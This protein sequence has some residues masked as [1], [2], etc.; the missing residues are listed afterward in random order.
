MRGLGCWPRLV[1]AG[2]LMAGLTVAPGCRSQ[3]Y[4]VEAPTAGISPHESPLVAA[5]F[6]DALTPAP[7]PGQ[8]PHGHIHVF[9]VNGVDPLNWGNM[10]GL[11]DHIRELHVAN[12]HEGQLYDAVPFEY[13]IRRLHRE[14]PDAHFVLIGFSLG[15][16]AVHMMAADVEEDGVPIDLLVY[17]SGNHVVMGLPHSRPAN[18][19]R[20]LNLLAGGIMEKVGHRDYAENIRVEGT[21]HFT[22]PTHPVTL[23]VLDRE[24][25]AV[26]NAGTAPGPKDP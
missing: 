9:L 25:S 8:A 13:D 16:N 26:A 20:V 12:I 10:A 24:L 7:A 11:R 6:H 22:L 2:L 4:A 15:A 18:V 19:G 17:L 1:G 23:G 14:E 21:R 3:H 5:S